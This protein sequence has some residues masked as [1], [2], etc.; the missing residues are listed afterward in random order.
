[1]CQEAERIV[2]TRKRR[3]VMCA[4]RAAADCF[5]M[6]RGREQGGAPA[7]E[8]RAAEEV[9]WS[10]ACGGGS[11]EQHTLRGRRP[12]C[13]GGA[14]RAVRRRGWVAGG[15]GL[16]HGRTPCSVVPDV[17]LAACG[18]DRDRERE[19]SR[20][21][22]MWPEAGTTRGPK[23]HRGHRMKQGAGSRHVLVSG[24]HRRG[25]ARSSAP[26]FAPQGRRDESGSR[27]TAA[28]FGSPGGMGQAR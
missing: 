9:R 26:A 27:R 14:R 17:L 23:S 13:A 22:C 21:V 19:D 3:R 1:M 12:E 20:T 5:W 18:A 25:D 7:L 2:E 4:R 15:R 6:T 16:G 11:P 10:A 28:L 24:Q 8:G